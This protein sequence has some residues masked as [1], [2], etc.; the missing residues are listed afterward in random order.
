MIFLSMVS[1]T[2]RDDIPDFIIDR[3]PQVPPFEWCAVCA[4]ASSSTTQFI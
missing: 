4:V 1:A 3:H 2:M